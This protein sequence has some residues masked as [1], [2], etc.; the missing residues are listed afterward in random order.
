M[1]KRLFCCCPSPACGP[2]QFKKP[3]IWHDLNEMEIY[4][5]MKLAWLKFHRIS[6]ADL[7]EERPP[8]NSDIR[9]EFD[10]NFC[11][12]TSWHML[13]I[14]LE[15][16]LVYAISR[17][18][19]FKMV[20]NAALFIWSNV[21]LHQICWTGCDERE[22]RES[23]YCS[24]LLEAPR[25]LPRWEKWS[26]RSKPVGILVS[27]CY[28][29]KKSRNAPWVNIQIGHWSIFYPMDMLKPCNWV[30]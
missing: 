20:D 18:W 24:T 14:M 2:T 23:A 13:P 17:S 26:Q 12:P 25:F 28:H 7:W 11:W 3:N 19:R 29:F 21:G 10:S 4:C 9:V 1:L 30:E 5:K 16:V 15:K 6:F 22:S 27:W 8:R